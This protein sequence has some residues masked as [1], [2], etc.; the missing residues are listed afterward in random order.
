MRHV[1]L[2]LGVILASSDNNVEAAAV[3]VEGMTS[4]NS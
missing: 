2:A 4:L 1:L 3:K